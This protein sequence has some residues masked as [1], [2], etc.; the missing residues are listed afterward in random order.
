MNVPNILQSPASATTLP[1]TNSGGG[2]TPLAAAGSPAAQRA[3]AA[4]IGISL[5]RLAWF[6]V[7]GDG[8]IDPRSADSGGDATLLVP[9]HEVDL[10][11]YSRAVSNP[12]TSRS[13]RAH[14]AGDRPLGTGPENAAQTNRA[15][16]SYH[17]Y[18]QAAAP[19]ALAGAPTNATVPLPGSG[20]PAVDTVTASAVG[21]PPPATAGTTTGNASPDVAPTKPPNS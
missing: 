4:R 2:T 11:T 10:P 5:T 3:H 13:A 21:V 20:P 1:R 7:N 17:R 14:A 19:I 12:P 18:G 16:G 15:V 9:T 8:R 6:D